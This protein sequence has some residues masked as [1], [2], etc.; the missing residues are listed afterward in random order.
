MVQHRGLSAQG[1]SRLR[2]MG[3]ALCLAAIAVVNLGLIAAR[4]AAAFDLDDVAVKAQQLA[5]EPYQE[6]TGQIPE[7]LRNITYDQWRDIRFRSEHALWHDRHLPFEAQFFHLGLYYPCPVKVNEVTPEGVRPVPFSTSQFDYGKNDFAA[8]IPE[9]LGYAGFRIHAP[10]KNPSYYDELIV[11]LGASYFR[12]LG[13]DQVFGLSARGLAVNTVGASPE[14]FPYFKEFWLVTPAPDA[15]ELTIYALLDGASVAGAYRFV[16][17]PGEQTIVN[18][19]VHLFPRRAGQHL[20]IAP[21]TSMFFH[22]ENT[23][24]PFVDFRPEVHD[25]DGLL[26]HFTSGEWLWRPLD[27]PPSIQVNA[28]QMQ[29]PRGFGLIQR[30]RDFDHHQDLEAHTE[31]RPSVWV[32]PRGDWGK[33]HVE[34]VE[35]PT[36]TDIN[37]NI[38]AYWVPEKPLKPG[39]SA[40]FAYTLYWYGDDPTRPPGG[41]VVAT[42]RDWGTQENVQRFVIDFAG[43]HLATLPADQ[44][45]RATVTVAGGSSVAELIDQQVVKNPATSGWRLGFAIRPKKN[46]PVEL[47]AF[48]AND[49]GALTETWSYA[50]TW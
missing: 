16:I 33:G 48:L 34:L 4:E 32:V 31:L 13:R 27:N 43:P 10:I 25:S 6:P 49:A 42:R 36:N 2:R 17:Q 19:D 29:N 26:L 3:R 12:A 21:L 18:V 14:E 35:L 28:L 50:A 20:G 45:P 8:A 44:P 5:A 11:F 22:G 40:S 9:D 7:W 37:D 46:Q 39:D 30:D 1:W 47:R 41:R 15:K 38:V 23:V 24:H